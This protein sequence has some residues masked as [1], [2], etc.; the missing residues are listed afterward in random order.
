MLCLHWRGGICVTKMYE[1]NNQILI[2]TD[3]ADPAEHRHIAAHLIISLG[4]NMTVLANGNAFDC[5]G[6]IIPPNTVHKVDTQ[7][8]PVLVFLFDST[9]SVASQIKDIQILPDTDCAHISYLFSEFERF[10]STTAYLQFETQVFHMLG[11]DAGCTVTDTRIADAMKTIRSQLSMPLSCGDVADSVFLS[12]GRFSHLFRQQV[13]MT[14]SAYLI[15]QRLLHVYTRILSGM[16][17]TEASLEAGFSSS[18]H[19]AEVNRRV[20]G[21]SASSITKNLIFT[22]IQ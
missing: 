4:R 9:T 1:F 3:Y 7:N 16:S 6:I 18:T 22:K 13:G 17:I 2:R 20:F 11:F 19:F 21:L 14:F 10:G 12:Q 15:Y 5:R 8:S